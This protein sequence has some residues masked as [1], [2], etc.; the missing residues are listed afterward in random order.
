MELE[1][2]SH[3]KKKQLKKHLSRATRLSEMYYLC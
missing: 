2:C 1:Q 3:L